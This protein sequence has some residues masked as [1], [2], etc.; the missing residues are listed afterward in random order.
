[1]PLLPGRAERRAGALDMAK[2]LKGMKF[3]ITCGELKQ[4]LGQAW[5]GAAGV[6]Q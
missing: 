1:M 4:S 6:E 2:E 5:A 3:S